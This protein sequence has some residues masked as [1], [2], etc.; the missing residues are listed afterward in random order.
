MRSMQS[1]YVLVFFVCLYIFHSIL[2]CIHRRVEQSHN[3]ISSCCKSALFFQLYSLCYFIVLVVFAFVFG[4]FSSLHL[5]FLCIFV[6]MLNGLFSQFRIEIRLPY[7][8]KRM[9][10]AN[11]NVWSSQHQ[12]IQLHRE[13]WTNHIY[14]V[15]AN[16][17]L[18]CLHRVECVHYD[19]VFE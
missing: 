8:P 18:Q 19:F 14:N 1:A 11:V 10:T 12:C 3:V 7:G 15:F 13:H 17:I 4:C 2:H 16:L 6:L 9:C 5:F